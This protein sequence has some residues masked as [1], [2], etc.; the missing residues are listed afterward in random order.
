MCTPALKN[1]GAMHR[2]ISQEENLELFEAE[3][4]VR[5]TSCH[6]ASSNSSAAGFT[7]VA[8]SG[9]AE[10]GFTRAISAGGF[11]RLFSGAG[12]ENVPEG[13]TFN[14]Q[15]STQAAVFQRIHSPDPGKKKK[16]EKEPEKL[17]RKCF[18]R[19]SCVIG[20]SR[21]AV[22]GLAFEFTDGTRVGH[23]LVEQRNPM[24]CSFIDDYELQKKWGWKAPLADFERIMSVSGH[25]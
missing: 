10:T 3:E 4:L 12:L 17:T 19:V 5:M 22:N 14:R 2:Q 9:L 1:E 20:G 23:F 13:V 6:V 21:P 18:Q 16:V 8:S 15:I 7:R 24:D 25:Y 11:T